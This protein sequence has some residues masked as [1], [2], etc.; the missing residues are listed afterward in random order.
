MMDIFKYVNLHWGLNRNHS[1]L[2]FLLQCVLQWLNEEK[3]I[4]RLVEIVHP[5]Q[6]EDV[7]SLLWLWTWFFWKKS[8]VHLGTEHRFTRCECRG[9]VLV[10]TW[11][12]SGC[13]FSK[14]RRLSKTLCFADTQFP[15]YETV[16]PGSCSISLERGLHL[17]AFVT[18]LF[19]TFFFHPHL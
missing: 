19:H 7:S 3:I 12:A 16:S 8:H 2:W 17:F 18:N 11:R 1:L 4:Q 15:E 13:Q 10:I 6:E 5:S 14:H 9:Q